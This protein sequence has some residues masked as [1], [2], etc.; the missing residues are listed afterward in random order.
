VNRP[1]P[2]TAART[3]VEA[4]LEEDLVCRAALD[5]APQALIVGGGDGVAVRMNRR[6][7]RLLGLADTARP[8][9]WPGRLPGAS[10]RQAESWCLLPLGPGRSEPFWIW[11][12]P[13]ALTLGAPVMV[14]HAIW[15]CRVSE[16]QAHA[17]GAD[18]GG[19]DQMMAVL[20]RHAL[21]GEMGGALAHQ[22]TQ[23]LNVIR[24][25]AERAALE[26][27][28]DVAR[29]K[30]D[31]TLADRF[32]KL[33][34]QAEAAFE[35][36]A[37]VQ[38]APAVTGP[39]DLQP[40]DLGAVMNR[41]AH[42]ARGPLRA[43]GLRVEVIS[44][45]GMP[46]VLAEP[47]LLLQI[48][49]AALTVLAESLGDAAAE[50]SSDARAAGRRLASP[51]GPAALVV[52]FDRDAAEGRLI[53]DMTHERVFRRDIPL[54]PMAPDLSVSRRVVLVAMALAGLGGHLMMLVDDLGALCGVRLDLARVLD[55]ARPVHILIAGDEAEAVTEMAE[56]LRDLD[57]VVT[58]AGTVPSALEA[59]EQGPHD[60]LVTD[61]SMPGGGAGALLRATAAAHPDL[62]VI[63]GTGYAIEHDPVQGD[64]VEMADA[65]L[66]K[67]FGLNELRIAI[68]RVLGA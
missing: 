43:A 32:V 21:L 56:F 41:A 34:D 59:L 11:S 50:A 47:V 7:R 60:V 33:A 61:L 25:T 5:A 22:I 51:S 13:L 42:L 27:E 1:P 26:A 36:V 14:L 48:G 40:V 62:A 6:A 37:L 52:R 28:R 29:G 15:P 4:E 3:A 46:M 31:L 19:F 8:T 10:P 55:R 2:E 57:Y 58:V 49:F 30:G 20:A 39:E 64:L 65:I 12:Q 38:G 67:P 23:P 17:A 54:T 35:T 18:Q 53:V 66:R 16:E 24:L 9:D 44:L 45:P 68:E 63:I